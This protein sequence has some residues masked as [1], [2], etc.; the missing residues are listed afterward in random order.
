VL[1]L[2]KAKKVL[3]ASEEKAKELDITVT[4]VVVDNSGI[5]IAS[6]KMDDALSVSPKFAQAKAFTSGTLGLP[7]SEIA[8]YAGPDKPYYGVTGLEGGIFTTIPGGLPIV[9]GG[10][11]VGGVGVGGS[12]DVNQDAECAQAGVDALG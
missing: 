5:L 10:N 2:E 6:H 11:L 4:T 8:K 3:K 12:Y 7:T 1:T 9:E